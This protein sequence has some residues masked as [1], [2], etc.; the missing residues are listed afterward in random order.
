LKVGLALGSGGARGI[1]HIAYLEVLDQLGI[2]TSA[3]A[4]SS[5]GALVG[6]LYAGG[7]SG[8][9]MRDI[10]EGIT[11]RDLPRFLD[12][13][14][15]KEAFGIKGRKIEEWLRE[16]LPIRNFEDLPIP[17][18]VV[19]TDFWKGE[20]VVFSSGDIA[21]AVRASISIPGV[22]QPYEL[23]GRVLV[24]GG[25][26]NPVPFDLLDDLADFVIAID[27]SG[28]ISRAEDSRVEAK[29]PGFV[30][31]LIHVFSIMGNVI[32]EQRAKDERIAMY[33]RPRLCGVRTGDFLKSG[34]IL[35]SV[36]DD[37][38]SFRLKLIAERFTKALS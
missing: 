34:E 3:I 23:D 15:F 19:A 9:R 32:M 2:E 26:V 6:A 37:A 8:R 36:R 20:Q 38:E 18:R 4:G 11:L 29:L 25:V 16:I 33:Q 5:I 21:H 13:P 10:A 28:E 27:V 35:D 7:L 31:T 12:A 30:E 24:D 14:S 1:A 17:L 22:F